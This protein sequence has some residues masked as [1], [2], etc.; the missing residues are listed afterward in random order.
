M[1]PLARRHLDRWSVMALVVVLTAGAWPT[2][3]PAQEYVELDGTVQWI[4]GQT[5]TLG[6]DTP[7]G[8]PSYVI[9]GPFLV[10]VPAP[11]QTVEVDL[12]NL[13]QADYAFMR[14]GER[15]TV[16]GVLSEDRRR[17]IATSL[18]RGSGPQ[19]P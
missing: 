18:I 14:T 6:L 9:S 11:R 16:I 10:P 12:S 15:L 17:V 19:A 7:S 5:L 4:A 13:R 3:A 8:P 2:A 1:G